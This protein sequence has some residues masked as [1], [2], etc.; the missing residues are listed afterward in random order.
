MSRKRR[1]VYAA[2]ML[3]P[4]AIDSYIEN[5]DLRKEQHHTTAPRRQTLASQKNKLALQ[6][7][8]QPPT[9][10]KEKQSR[11]SEGKQEI[12]RFQNFY[13][14]TAAQNDASTIELKWRFSLILPS[15]FLFDH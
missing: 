8:S 5:A 13:W 7:R 12:L 3:A 11:P 6:H 2:G 14:L 10:T 15:A 1:D 4:S 9:I